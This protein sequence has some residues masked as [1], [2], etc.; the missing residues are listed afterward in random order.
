MTTIAQE[1]LDLIAETAA[2]ILAPRFTPE[3]LDQ[4]ADWDEELWDALEDTGLTLV[5]ADADVSWQAAVEV[6][7]QAGRYAAAVPL[8]ETQV[9][10]WLLTRCD[11]EVPAGPLSV[12]LGG[13]ARRV[14]YG[15]IAAAV[16]VAAADTVH[17]VRPDGVVR[18]EGANLA[19]EPRDDLTG[20]PAG[21]SYPVPPG[22]LALAG[23]L[24]RL[25][26]AAQILG[27]AE[28]CVE[29]TTGY[30]QERR[31]F[32]RA[33]ARFQAVQQQIAV[34][35]GE[36]ALM[37]AAVDGAVAALADDAAGDHAAFA[38]D[39]T[40]IQVGVGATQVA[41]IAHQLHGAIGT[42]REHRLRLATTRLWAWCA[43]DGPEQELCV[44]L[45][46]QVLSAGPDQ[47]WPDIAR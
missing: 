23:A 46:A 7:V 25:L 2:R 9:A 24:L 33:L 40:K 13:E 4:V 45:G 44:R 12:S 37:R 20:D 39:S 27:A 29:L 19:G 5:T 41:R 17:V 32:G 30:V 43:E 14:P 1:E 42:T 16:V 22:A 11:V 35:A 10:A 21:A 8:V 31:Q 38:V 18:A 47:V 36:T 28:Q 6:A 3:H 26:R 34:M 15:R